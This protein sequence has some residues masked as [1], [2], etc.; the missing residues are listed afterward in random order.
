MT[1]IFVLF[2]LK[3]GVTPEAYEAW[4]KATDLPTVRGL[5]SVASFNVY[6]ASGLLGT[7][8]P[9]PY[10]YIETIDVN[11]MEQFGADVS[12]Q[13]MQKVAAEFQEVA[14]NPCFILTG[15]IEEV[16]S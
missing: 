5:K 9:S 10:A 14:D 13:T 12:S 6:R 3:D 15:D 8:D 7:D 1:Q 11:D 16:A 4:A 2:N